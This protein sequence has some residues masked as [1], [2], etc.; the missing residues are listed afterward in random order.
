MAL[1]HAPPMRG[2][3]IE[4]KPLTSFPALASLRDCTKTRH[5]ILDRAMPLAK[6][7]PNWDNYVEHLH[8]LFAWLQPIEAHLEKFSNGPQSANAPQFIHYSH[9]IYKD[10]GDFFQPPEPQRFAWSAMED[11]A[12][13][14]GICYVVEGSQLGG[15]FLYK[16]L[17]KAL[18]PHQLVYLQKK[19]SGR[20]PAFL[21]C[22]AAEL[23]TQEQIDKACEGAMD[24]FDAL[25]T[26]LQHR[27]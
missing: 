26:L 2:E 23:T 22:M 6:P 13:R 3:I 1:L 5:N 15:E 24:A 4:P 27:E 14:W 17:A 20:W 11:P 18:S 21:S 10:L 9:I 25:L 8:I 16:S 7:N 19:Q 12:Y